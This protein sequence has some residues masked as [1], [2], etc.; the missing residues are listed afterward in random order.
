MATLLE[1]LQSKGVKVYNSEPFWVN[2]ETI[3]SVT[4]GENCVV[5]DNKF[6]SKQL[7][8]QVDG[9]MIYIALKF[10]VPADKPAYKLTAYT[11]SRDWPEYHLSAGETKVFAE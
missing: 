6:G 3:E 5:A 4:I 11:A 8:M 9:Q 2:P 1:K 7:V 10:G